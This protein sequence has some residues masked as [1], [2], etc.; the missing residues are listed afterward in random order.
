MD[1]IPLV[2]IEDQ[3]EMIMNLTSFFSSTE[4]KVIFIK[5]VED[6]DDAILNHSPKIII[7]DDDIN[8]KSYGSDIAEIVRKHRIFK[9]IILIGCSAY[10]NAPGLEREYQKIGF[11]RFFDNDGSDDQ[12]NKI[13]EYI[14]EQIKFS[15]T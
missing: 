12:L 13:V 11:D 4:F 8:G 6:L 9:K 2:F 10:A 3:D 14:R 1:K 15:K 7:S 5:K